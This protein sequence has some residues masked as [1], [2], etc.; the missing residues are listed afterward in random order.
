[1]KLTSLILLNF[2]LL[3]A[4][5]QGRVPKSIYNF[6]VTAHNGGIIDF[7][8][9]KGKK[10]LIVNTMS[11]NNKNH[12]YAELEATYQKYKNKLVIIGFLTDDFAKP[13]GKKRDTTTVNKT[14]NVTFPLAAK[15]NI[16][17]PGM[18]P[19]YKWLT[20]K[21]NNKLK[22]TEVSGDFVKF[23]VD[24]KG[25]LIAVFGTMDLA[26]GPELTAAIE[27]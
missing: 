15:V 2:L 25:K 12:Q 17:E 9:Y 1:M 8:K 20:Q 3:S 21:K 6:K 24:E 19:I 7:A 14:Y 18:A 5:A 13:P 27:K 11:I 16:Q 23:L 4:H 10:I 22:D 26:T